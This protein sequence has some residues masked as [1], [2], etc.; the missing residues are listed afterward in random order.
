MRLK[1]NAVLNDFCSAIYNMWREEYQRMLITYPGILNRPGVATNFM[2]LE[3]ESESPIE[4]INNT[5]LLQR[6]FTTRTQQ[7]ISDDDHVITVDSYVLLHIYHVLRTLSDC[8]WC[9]DVAEEHIRLGIRHELGHAVDHASYMGKSMDEAQSRR[10]MTLDGY[11]TLAPPSSYDPVEYWLWKVKYHSLPVERKADEL[12]GI[13]MEDM[14]VDFWMMNPDYDLSNSTI[15]NY[16][17][18]DRIH[19]TKK[20]LQQVGYYGKMEGNKNDF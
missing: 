7:E 4:N 6:E 11:A 10:N 17:S 12:A 15:M 1:Y 8:D 14:A 20:W 3:K 2:I 9:I 13:T 19:E 5:N 18:A 16:I